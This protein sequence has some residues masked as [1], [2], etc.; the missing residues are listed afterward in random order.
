LI[1][2]MEVTISASND[3]IACAQRRCGSEISLVCLWSVI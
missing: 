3:V 1:C 2:G